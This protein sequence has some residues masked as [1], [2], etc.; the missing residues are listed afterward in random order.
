MGS[1]LL[2][3]QRALG[4]GQAAAGRGVGRTKTKHHRKEGRRGREGRRGGG[5]RAGSVAGYYYIKNTLACSKTRAAGAVAAPS[6]C[7]CKINA[8]QARHRE[9]GWTRPKEGGQKTGLRGGKETREEEP[10]PGWVA[11]RRLL[12]IPTSRRDPTQS[13]SFVVVGNRRR[14]RF[15]VPRLRISYRSRTR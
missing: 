15:G 5:A 3:G 14:S 13:R 4:C 1:T 12:L 9:L 7:C 10:G 6:H 2:S 8:R 11:G